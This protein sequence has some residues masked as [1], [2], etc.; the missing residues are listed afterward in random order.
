MNLKVADTILYRYMWKLIGTK[1]ITFYIKKTIPLYFS[2]HLYF[3]QR[4]RPELLREFYRSITFYFGKMPLKIH[5]TRKLAPLWCCPWNQNIPNERKWDDRIYV[6]VYTA[7][8]MLRLLRLRTMTAPPLL[9]PTD[10][11]DSIPSKDLG[12]DL[13]IS[14]FK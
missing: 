9:Y 2:L 3:V 6:T 5:W 4:W 8:K 12:Y 7:E 10:V 13:F 1:K 14:L 11:L